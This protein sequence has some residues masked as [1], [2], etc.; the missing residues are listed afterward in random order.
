[1]ELEYRRDFEEVR[2][3]WDAFWR[4]EFARRPLV[5]IT[6][7]KAGA[8]PVDPP[9]YMAG[10]EGDYEAVVQQVVDSVGSYEYLGEAV[11]CYCF[12]FAPDHFTLLLGGSERIHNPDSGPTAWIEP[13]VEDWD[14]TPIAF[15]R[16]CKWW[17]RTVEFAQALR[18]RCEGKMVLGGP[19][20]VAGLDAMS[21][22]RGPERFMLDLVE[23]PDAV[24]RALERMKA[25]Y[26]EVVEAFEELLGS[27]R[28]GSVTRHGLYSRGRI[29]CNQC[30][31]SC[32]IGPGMF[33]EFA[34]PWLEWEMGQFDAVEYH[35]DGPGAIKHLDRLCAMEGLDVVQW[36]S[37]A[38]WGEQ[39]DWTGLL[40]R[41][42]AL[43]K[44]SW[45][46]GENPSTVMGLWRE[47][48]TNKLCFRARLAGR[49]E[50]EGLLAE[51]EKARR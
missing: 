23:R 12:E 4:G 21:V 44:G 43:G 51:L 33:E 25:A 41:I 31:C 13:Y 38:G 8:A 45:L 35:L 17:R 39:Q 11:P 28:W 29:T 2:L 10:A 24:K 34:A 47:F 22:M 42:D 27:K 49:S 19:T 37:G 36:V 15:D 50:A 6:V 20:L 40:R 48:R 3:R 32:M 1:M 14:E 46:G 7:P 5:A 18:A 16:S 9:A 30:D 26:V